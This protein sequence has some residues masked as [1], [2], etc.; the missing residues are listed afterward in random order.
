VHAMPRMTEF[1]RTN[2]PW[3]Q[4][5]DYGNIELRTMSA[6]DPI[7]LAPDLTVTPI[8]VP[9]RQEYA[10][11]VGFVIEGPN[12]AVLYVPDI[13][14]W[15]EW[16]AMGTTLEEIIARVDIALLDATFYDDNEIPGR[17]MSTFPHPRITETMRRLQHLPDGKR[18]NIGFIHLNH[19]NPAQWKDTPERREIE[20]RGFTVPARG[21]VF[22]L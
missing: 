16:P 12:R 19:T 21:D 15:D 5:V 2:G 20:R 8:L 3:S 10:E 4:L 22:P 14:R 17:D 6:N 18:A 11:V 13:D 1:L 9:H 7:E